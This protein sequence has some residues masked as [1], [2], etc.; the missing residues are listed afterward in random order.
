MRPRLAIV[1]SQDTPLP[2]PS[3]DTRLMSRY[4]G[5]ES[6]ET[7]TVGAR[8]PTELARRISNTVQFL[9]ERGYNQIENRNDF[10]RDAIVYFLDY[11]HEQYKVNNSQLVAEQQRERLRSEM[12]QNV[13]QRER[14]LATVGDMRSHIQSLMTED[15]Y[16]QAW[17][18]IITYLRGVSKFP[19]TDAY[20]RR[21][22]LR[23]LYEDHYLRIIVENL[24]F[25]GYS[26]PTLE[27]AEEWAIEDEEDE[28]VELRKV[29]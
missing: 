4:K 28:G 15:D 29:A 9:H 21:L 16:E 20:W 7:V 27:E 1:P 26:V 25:H 24:R 6:K 12:E 23:S 5:T 2:E 3:V 17:K 8:V 10:I 14:L 19:V 13:Q 22:Y 18:T 11:V